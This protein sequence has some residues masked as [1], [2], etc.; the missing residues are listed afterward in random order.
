MDQCIVES[1]ELETLKPMAGLFHSI[2]AKI[3]INMVQNLA[4]GDTQV[5]W[6][7]KCFLLSFLYLFLINYFI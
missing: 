7:Y 3:Y 2:L 5:R 4:D 6:E 1:Y